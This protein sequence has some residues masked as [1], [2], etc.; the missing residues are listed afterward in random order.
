MVKWNGS[1]GQEL[2][3]QGA[4]SGKILFLS[5]SKIGEQKAEEK[6]EKEG[7]EKE[8]KRHREPNLPF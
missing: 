5:Y 3:G 6:Q 1:K 4:I 2:Q 8:K 7:E